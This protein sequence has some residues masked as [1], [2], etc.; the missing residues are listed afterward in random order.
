MAVDGDEQFLESIARLQAMKPEALASY[1]T[2]ARRQALSRYHPARFERE[3][4]ETFGWR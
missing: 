3:V 2:A 1:V 4:L